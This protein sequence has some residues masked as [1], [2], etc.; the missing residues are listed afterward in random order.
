METLI[1]KKRLDIDDIKIVE[2]SL[3]EDPK[4]KDLMK[5]DP[6][7]LDDIQAYFRDKGSVEFRMAA[8]DF[9]HKFVDKDISLEQVFTQEA[10]ESLRKM[11]D[12]IKECKYPSL[13]T[14][15]AEKMV[16]AL[17][18]VIVYIY[19]KSNPNGIKSNISK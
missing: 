10:K 12:V 9:I 19:C 18:L 15:Y 8:T 2:S 14:H 6:T 16:M 13:P 17:I 3:D 4:W 7:F 5:A 1:L 11:A